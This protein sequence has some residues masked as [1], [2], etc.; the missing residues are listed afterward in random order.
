MK[1]YNFGIINNEEIL[2]GLVASIVFAIVGFIFKYYIKTHYL[3]YVSVPWF[4][5]WVFRKMS[6]HIFK[7]LNNEG[8]INN[9]LYSTKLPVFFL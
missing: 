2:E 7:K 3:I 9:K 6:V 4:I 5:T 8:Y 1:L